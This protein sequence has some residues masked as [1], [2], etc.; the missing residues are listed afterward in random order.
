MSPFKALPFAH[1][2]RGLFCGAVF[3]VLVDGLFSWSSV[4]AQ[5]D[6]PSDHRP[7][8]KTEA[9]MPDPALRFRLVHKG[10]V[11]AVAFSLPYHCVL[12]LDNYGCFR[13]WDVKAVPEE[14]KAPKSSTSEERLDT[15]Y[16]S[17]L[18]VSPNG[19]LAAICDKQADSSDC[20]EIYDIRQMKKVRNIEPVDEFSGARSL[21]FSTQG[22]RL[23]G[24]LQF[25]GALQWSLK[26][27]KS[28]TPKKSAALPEN[29]AKNY[30]WAV[31]VTHLRGDNVMAVG[32]TGSSV[33]FYNA[34]SGQE[35]A[36]LLLPLQMPGRK[37]FVPYQLALSSDGGQ[38]LVVAR[39]GT[40]FTEQIKPDNMIT[41]W[42]MTTGEPVWTFTHE[43]FHVGQAAFSPDGRY[44]AV[45]FLND[46]VVRL[47]RIADTKE[48]AAFKGHTLGVACIAFSPDGTMIASGGS[49]KTAIVWN[50]KDGLLAAAERPQAEKD[51][52]KCWN[53]LR[54]GKP[55]EAGE[56]VAS[57]AA[58]QDDAVK[59]LE[60]K[61]P[62]VGKPDAVKVKKWLAQ[63]NDDAQLKRDEA[64]RE[65]ATLGPLIET[66]VKNALANPP[67]AE[68]KRRLQELQR[69]MRSLWCSDPDTVRAVRAVYVLERIGS[70][71][72]V[73]L[74]KKLAEGEIAARLTREAKIS[75]ERLEVRKPP[76]P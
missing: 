33:A 27:R 57:L 60:S 62:P 7:P 73:A 38:L 37:D 32:L 35:L 43:K 71:K 66:E 63:L 25:C 23:A 9:A 51:F 46:P 2:A 16:Y 53:T 76:K 28:L 22:D 8:E 21:S 18:T 20:I 52:A 40:A 1:V 74:L 17:A 68:V 67:S 56:A 15:S 34:Q 31:A 59:W 65:L 61:L 47:Y 72:A 19:R 30:N 75:L 45:G 12:T 49:D 3:V 14:V 58:A 64:S 69:E 44:V 55:L 5:T 6:S 10:L 24:A 42:D 54:A 39:G 29:P 26:E 41:L 70:E 4:L 50:V 13:F 11:K 36:K 48:V